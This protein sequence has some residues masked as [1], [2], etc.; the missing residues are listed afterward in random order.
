MP[1]TV[2][3]LLKDKVVLYIVL[4]FSVTNVIGYLMLHNL[5]AVLI[6]I[7]IGLLTTYFSQN[8]IIVLLTALIATNAI[9]GAQRAGGAKEGFQEGKEGEDDAHKKKKAP[10][11]KAPGKKL[12][13]MEGGRRDGP[14][15]AA[16]AAVDE[17][18]S[19]GKPKIDYAATL[20]SAYDNLDKLLGSD[21]LAN[22]SADTQKLAQKQ[23]ALMANL[24]KLE[25]MIQK[26]G[27]MLEGLE[28]SGGAVG[29]LMEKFGGLAGN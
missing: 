25:P 2:S 29:K 15:A 24:G 13:G 21:A 7:V 12:E 28:Q 6:F 20:E 27:S 26:A 23:E 22:M 16:P 18:E 17:E 1:L 11:K 19:G 8:M 9:V 4:F 5:E 14:V 3:G 10:G